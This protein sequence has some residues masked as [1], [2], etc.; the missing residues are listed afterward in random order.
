MQTDRYKLFQLAS[1]FAPPRS[2]KYLSKWILPKSYLFQLFPLFVSLLLARGRHQGT[3][4]NARQ[5]KKF[6]CALKKNHYGKARQKIAKA[7][8]IQQYAKRARKTSRSSTR[9]RKKNIMVYR[10]LEKIRE[11][12][13]RQKKNT[14]YVTRARTL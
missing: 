2:M 12:N 9:A 13:S 10:A 1:S 7:L 6:E 11:T 14:K 8:K 4:L 3:A 5:K